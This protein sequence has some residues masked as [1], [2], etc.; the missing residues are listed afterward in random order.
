MRDWWTVLVILTSAAFLSATSSFSWASLRA[1]EY[2]SSSSS[3]PFSF[4]CSATRSSSSC[5]RFIDWLTAKCGKQSACVVCAQRGAR[6]HSR[7]EEEKEKVRK[8]QTQWN[9]WVATSSAA[10]SFSSTPWYSSCILS[11]SSSVTRNFFS[12]W[13][14]SSSNYTCIN[15]RWKYC[16]YLDNWFITSLVSFMVNWRQLTIVK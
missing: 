11:R 5:V 9:T 10:R 12:N 3:V 2:L 13:I 15:D 16:I 14:S 8:I 6:A 4:F 1:S 7:T